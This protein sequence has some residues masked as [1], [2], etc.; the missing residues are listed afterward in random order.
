MTMQK[1]NSK[2]RKHLNLKKKKH[3][4]LLNN[5]TQYKVSVNKQ[6]RQ[7]DRLD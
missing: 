6:K 7:G 4:N 5:C 3:R 2:W 1:E